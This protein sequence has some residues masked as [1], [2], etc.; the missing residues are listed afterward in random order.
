MIQ[1]Q[2]IAIIGS[3]GTLGQEFAGAC[4]RRGLKARAFSGR[5]DLD[6][7]DRAAVRDALGS[8]RSSIVINASGFTDVDG[9][10]TDSRSAF[11]VNRDGAAHLAETCRQIGALLVHF[12]TDY[13]F[14][15]DGRPL[16]GVEA[17]PCPVNVYG[18]S[19]LA[20]ERAI[21]AAQGEHLILRTSWLFGAGGA[22]FVDA[23]LDLAR[24]RSMIEVVSDQIGRPS[25][26]RHVA[27]TT[28][29]L[30]DLG[31]RGTYHMTN[32]GSCSRYELA[33]EI[34]ATADLDCRVLPC[35]TARHP[36]RAHR[37]R[38]SVLDLSGTIALLGRLPHWKT[39]LGEYVEEVMPR[40]TCA[41]G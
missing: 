26:C 19:K 10:E 41:A 12:S 29:R 37:P 1:E 5:H 24:E 31:V 28:L 35:E 3:G 14:G 21:R 15:G 8:S 32:D 36:R 33:R 16:Y 34:V 6:V 39:A 13:I 27:E 4:V 22:S 17:D 38:R 2:Q 20:G 40:A 7:T 9:A 23:I 25:R 30:V 11:S 18:L